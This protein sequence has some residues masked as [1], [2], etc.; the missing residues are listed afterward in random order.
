MYLH[1][2][3]YIYIYTYGARGRHLML[4]GYEG[5]LLRYVP[6][7]LARMQSASGRVLTGLYRCPV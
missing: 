4:W 5:L 3:T 1:T 2:H 6:R 7:Q